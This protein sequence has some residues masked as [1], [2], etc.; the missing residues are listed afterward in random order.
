MTTFL[1]LAVILL[2]LIILFQISK[3]NELVSS[4]RG[5]E[6][7]IS[8][9][10]NNFH[11]LLFLI[12]L[13][14][15]MVG[16]FWSAWHYSDLYLPEPSSVH[17]VDLRNMFYYTLVATVPVFVVTHILL[18]YFSYRYS[19][20]EGKV[21]YHF[22]HSNRLELVWTAIPAVVLVLLVF[23]GLRTWIAITG[24]AAE[25]A[26]VV[27]ATAEQFQWTLRYSGNDNQLGKKRVDQIGGE[28]PLGQVWTDQANHDDFISTELHLPV[29]TPVL[30]RI[31]AKD[32]LH[33]FFLPHFRVKMDAVPGIPT[34]FWFTPTKTTEQM[35]KELGNPNFNYELACAELCGQ[36][37]YNMRRLVVVETKEEFQKWSKEQQPTYK[38]LGLDKKNPSLEEKTQE[39][40]LSEQE[41]EQKAEEKDDLAATL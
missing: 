21:G 17:G 27:E 25:G 29:N 31:N 12:F 19:G 20:K 11:G 16:A 2:V 6:D 14:L 34:Q 9:K 15:G 3:A 23:E 7:E 5:E 37:H 40:Q 13:V 24:P 28:N 41:E 32:V 36:A 35:R 1:G 39:E 33:S 30:V 22:A 8:D 4:I 38:A 26:M 18:F 10:T